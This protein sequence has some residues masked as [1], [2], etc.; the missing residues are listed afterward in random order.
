MKTPH[1][2]IAI[3][4]ASLLS[5]AP[6]GGRVEPGTADFE[7]TSADAECNGW[8]EGPAMTSERV[9]H[10]MT[11]LPDGRVLVTG[12]TDASVAATSTTE[13]WNP[14]GDAWAPGPSLAVPR[15]GHA[16]VLLDDGTVLLM[17]GTDDVGNALDSTE[18]FNPADD[19][20]TAGA[21]MSGPHG[22]PQAV[23]V[24][25]GR[26]LLMDGDPAATEPTV[27]FYDPVKAV[28]RSPG[29][30]WSPAPQ[31]SLHPFGTTMVAV[32]THAPDSG[33]PIGLEFW[34]DADTRGELGE[35]FESF[36][37]SDCIGNGHQ[38]IRV[39]S[40]RSI[41]AGGNG[42]LVSLSGRGP[43]TSVIDTDGTATDLLPL[44][45]GTVFL[46]APGSAR[47]LDPTD[48]SIED[49]EPLP[50]TNV[51]AVVRTDAVTMVTGG[52]DP[53]QVAVATT[54]VSCTTR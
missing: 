1:Q 15:T 22:E 35:Q 49:F 31:P 16:A 3:T 44:G 42:C 45:N 43:S 20:L 12:G 13:L 41:L 33:D 11:L 50:A 4:F 54:W 36:Q 39:S 8:A 48:D 38:S 9:D 14:I 34:Y 26:V 27:D 25:A 10:T 5:C 7:N 18:I 19:T 23:R 46:G 30:P 52:V 29:S 37:T 2:L 21:T 17:G 32:V 47:V 40:E 24:P 6:P 51:Q 28:W 53:D